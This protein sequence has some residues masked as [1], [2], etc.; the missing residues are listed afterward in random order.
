M[1]FIMYV[2][3]IDRWMWCVVIT[4]SNNC[5]DWIITS[6]KETQSFQIYMGISLH[7]RPYYWTKGNEWH[8]EWHLKRLGKTRL[9]YLRSLPS[10]KSLF[11]GVN[12]QTANHSL[13]KM[14]FN[15]Q[16][17]SSEHKTFRVTPGSIGDNISIL[18]KN[19]TRAYL[20]ILPPRKG[21]WACDP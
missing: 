17:I 10:N 3:V 12:M 21:Y 18:F 1:D 5:F 20:A 11:M 15:H 7:W 6:W 9:E 2:S 8:V 13:F 16:D 14:K 19:F 4:H